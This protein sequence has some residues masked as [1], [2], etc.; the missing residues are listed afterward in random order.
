MN[1]A[2]YIVNTR[3]KCPLPFVVDTPLVLSRLIVHI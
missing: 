2:I 1:F 3:V